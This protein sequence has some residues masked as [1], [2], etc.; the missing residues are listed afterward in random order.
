[1][2]KKNICLVTLFLLLLST[3]SFAISYEDALV[4]LAERNYMN[5]INSGRIPLQHTSSW[6]D[7][8]KDYENGWNKYDDGWKY[9]DKYYSGKLL[10]GWYKIGEDTY[11]FYPENNVMA[12]NTVI[13]GYIIGSDG[14]RIENTGLSGWQQD[15]KGW[16]YFDIS[17]HQLTIGWKQ[18]DGGIY[19]FATD[20]YMV[21]NTVIDG[22]TIGLD[23]KMID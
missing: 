13:D 12:S 8:H 5:D 23:G 17:T 19:Y 10:S 21:A 1:M 15:E 16:R 6:T 18:I 7:E 2:F 11:Y 22:H 20:G 4:G 3:H 14:K 9:Y